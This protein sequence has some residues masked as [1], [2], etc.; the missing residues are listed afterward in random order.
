MDTLFNI[1]FI[2][3]LAEKCRPKTL[4]EYIGQRHLL[5]SGKIISSMIETERPL[6]LI[7]WGPP[8]TGKTTLARLLA[9]A[10]Q[11][12][13]YFLSA[14]SAGVADAKKIILKGKE[15]R[16]LGVKTLLFL[17]EIHRFNKAQQDSVLGAVENGDIVLI[18]ATTENPS[19]SIISPLLSRTRIIKLNPFSQDE[20]RQIY[21]NSKEKNIISQDINF[22]EAVL[23]KLFEYSC[24]DARRMYNI[25]ESSISCASGNEITEDIF[26]EAI[27]SLP[28]YFDKT[29]DMHYDTISAFIKSMRGSDPNAAVFY[30]ARMLNGGEDPVFIARRMIIFASEDVGNASVQALNLAVSTLTAVQNIGMPE[31]RIILSQCAIFLACAPK[32]N[33]CYMAIDAAMETAKSSGEN[34][35]L[36]IRNAPTNMMKDFGYGKGYKYPHDFPGNFVQECYLPEDIKNMVFY[37]PSENGQEKQIKERLE[38]L[39]GGEVIL[40]KDNVRV[41]NS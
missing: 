4:N 37:K 31:C 27:N 3:P 34:I 41:S 39:W 16:A 36:H 35:P 19:F 12:D 1:N 21:L 28:S 26:L 22:P 29:G 25:I 7:L 30:L 18:G 32:S 10:F 38:I 17:D 23:N 13:S 20:L 9:E 40:N 2:T 6:S 14:I 11:M 24:G 8:G 33:A 5:D 15:N